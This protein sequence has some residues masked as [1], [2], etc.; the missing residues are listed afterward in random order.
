M[1]PVAL[2]VPEQTRHGRIFRPANRN[3]KLFAA[4]AGVVHF[5][6]NR[7]QHIRALGFE[8]AET[9]GQPIPIPHP[10][11]GYGCQPQPEPK[12]VLDEA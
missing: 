8:V 10:W 1:N 3:A 2:F 4:V 5:P 12:H 11:K 7:L 6:E 9:S